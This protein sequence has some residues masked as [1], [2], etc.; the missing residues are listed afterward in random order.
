MLLPTHAKDNIITS[1][2]NKCWGYYDVSAGRV[3][4]TY[5]DM[6]RDSSQPFNFGGAQLP[7]TETTVC[8]GG[9]VITDDATMYTRNAT[10]FLTDFIFRPGADRYPDIIFSNPMFLWK[11]PGSIADFEEDVAS[12]VRSVLPSSAFWGGGGNFRMPVHTE[13]AV[14]SLQPASHEESSVGLM[15]RFSARPP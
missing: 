7:Q 12:R 9:K 2:F 5:Q 13:R 14:S 1:E 3:R 8:H 10:K 11:L 4:L 15:G 6:M